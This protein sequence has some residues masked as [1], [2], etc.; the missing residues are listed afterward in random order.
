MSINLKRI[1]FL[2][3]IQ[4]C[5]C[6]SSCSRPTGRVERADL[7]IFFCLRIHFFSVFHRLSCNRLIARSSF[8]CQTSIFFSFFLSSFFFHFIL[9][10][11]V[12]VVSNDVHQPFLD[13]SLVQMV[14]QEQVEELM[15]QYQ[16]L[17]WM[18]EQELQVLLPLQVLP[19]S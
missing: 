5:V 6:T 3:V 12:C 11:D 15:Q 10:H 1:F 17:E 7:R 16:L 4:L 2:Y 18:Y 8:L 19:P 9:I 13:L 14:L